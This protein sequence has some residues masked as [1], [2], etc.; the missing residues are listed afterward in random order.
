MAHSFNAAAAEMEGELNVLSIDDNDD[1]FFLYSKFD[2][3]DFDD[4]DIGDTLGEDAAAEGAV[5]IDI[6][7]V[8]GTILL[9]NKIKGEENI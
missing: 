1:S 6:D 3:E 8:L 4:G 5:V 9:S 7:I 2:D